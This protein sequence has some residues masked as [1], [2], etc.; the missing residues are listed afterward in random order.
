MGQSIHH[1]A[2]SAEHYHQFHQRLETELALLRP[3]LEEPQ[4]DRV[5]PS[6]GAELEMYLVDSDW[7]PTPRNQWLLDQRKNPLVQ[8]ELNQY[9]IEF[10][11]APVSAN[12]RSLHALHEQLENELA[13]LRTIAHQQQVR[14]VPI[15]VLP[16]LD[17]RHLS[18]EYLT[19]RPRY[20]VLADQLHNLK[21]SAFDVD[22][23]GIDNLKMRSN[24]VTLEG[25]NT[26]FQLHLRVRSSEFVNTFNAA[27][28][29][30]PLVLALAANSPILMGKQLWHETR[31]ALFKQSI[32]SRDHA[33]T[34]WRQPAR[35]S[36]GHG[37]LRNSVY[38]LFAENVAL[39][40]A[41][42]PQVP[43][44]AAPDAFKAIQIHQGTI[45]SWNRPVLDVG[46][47]PHLRIEFRTL[48][49]GPSN[50]D[51]IANAALLLGLTTALS[52]NIDGYINKLPFQ[53]AEFNFYRAAQQGLN[54]NIVWP[55]Q[56]QHQLTERKISD[57]IA[58][59]LPL[60]ETGLQQL[61]VHKDDINLY[62]NVI[63]R[64][65]AARQTGASW[66]LATFKKLSEKGRANP[67]A[68]LIEQY[69][70]NN[71]ANLPVADWD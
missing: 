20:H 56:H 6:L 65:L 21:G 16:T 49:A 63:E 68:E 23:N 61:G 15:G 3:L 25:A 66:Q 36:F 12:G 43:A 7:L 57:V 69:T 39:Y 9:N 59:L 31:I 52:H 45:W 50:I 46:N 14:I 24:E 18:H 29:V 28:L 55:Q 47:D 51:M 22:I 54:A 13:A 60:A 71:I 44:E 17:E 4:F 1:Q 53:Y 67:L 2:F 64:R 35:V 34:R 42:L 27:Q 37:W 38:E 30:T 58:D 70:L 48:P 33:S 10:N 5:A 8:P 32:D 11:L 62:L 26:S 40:P 41:L 19:N